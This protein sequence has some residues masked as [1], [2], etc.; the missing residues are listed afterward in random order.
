[1]KINGKQYDA[2]ALNFGAMCTLEKWGLQI[3]DLSSRPLGFLAG[4]VALA[5][6]GDLTAG[7]AAIDAHLENGGNL[8]EISDALNKA[9]DESGFF[10]ATAGESKTPA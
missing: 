6:G 3:G 4:F 9:V 10:K 7:Q 5:I 8:E 1:M 2:P